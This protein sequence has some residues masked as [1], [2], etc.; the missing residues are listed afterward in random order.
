MAVYLKR[1]LM[2][3]P[4]ACSLLET[5]LRSLVGRSPLRI[6]TVGIGQHIM[7]PRV[8]VQNQGQRCNSLW[9]T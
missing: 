8:E 7:D 9:P 2:P 5:T 3:C 6:R 1:L 4:F